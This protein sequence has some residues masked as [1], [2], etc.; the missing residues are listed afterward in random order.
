MLP[1]PKTVGPLT[2]ERKTG[3][4]GVVDTWRAAWVADGDRPVLARRLVDWVVRDADVL[5]AVEARI[6]DLR[7]LRHPRLVRILDYLRC[8]DERYIIEEAVRGIDLMTLV[9]EV[10]ALGGS[11]PPN[12]LLHIAIQLCTNLEALHHNR[13][14][15]TGEDPMLHRSLRPSAVY[16]SLEGSVRLGGYGLLPSPNLIPA[17]VFRGPVQERTAFLAPEQVDDGRE[18]SKATDIFSLG[19]ILYTMLTGEVLFSAPSD[20]QAVWLIRQADVDGPIQ[21]S[22]R[23]LPGI[24]RVLTRCLYAKPGRRYQSVTTL[25]EDLR[26]LS[27]QYDMSRITDDILDLLAAVGLEPPS[28]TTQPAV[29]RPVLAEAVEED[30]SDEPTAQSGNRLIEDEVTA[31]ITIT[32]P[33][34]TR[35]VG[36]ANAAHGRPAHDT[37]P[38]PLG[39]GLIGVDGDEL[40]EVDP[41]A[42]EQ[43]VD[44]DGFTET[45]YVPEER[46]RP[47]PVITL[48][49]PTAQ[50]AHV[51]R[52]DLEQPPAPERTARSP[53]IVQE[54]TG[55]M[56]AV[57]PAPPTFVPPA[58]TGSA[59]AGSAHTGSSHTGSGHLSTPA[60]QPTPQ[61]A[62]DMET[63]VPAM[64]AA[65]LGGAFL[66][67]AVFIGFAITLLQRPPP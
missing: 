21:E 28:R 43:V 3:T 26:G 6:G 36:P 7:E 5:S 10:H 13:G 12:V 51:A 18:I 11:L 66:I 56:A 47:A 37:V 57:A 62:Q 58:H 27:A 32:D 42:L 4:D 8:D 34:L 60:S 25:R 52:I 1:Q 33:S 64:R 46:P 63:E 67:A 61:G 2:L 14:A 24:D 30:V 59:H 50:S 38:P 41:D 16:V 39:L 15:V 19:A 35:P 29:P 54:T 9:Q 40:D 17:N 49:R 22:R 31:D 65:V 48:P 53:I 23:Q 55:R 20:L 44:D 45:S